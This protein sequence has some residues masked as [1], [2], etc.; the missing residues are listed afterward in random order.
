MFFALHI[1]LM[2]IATLGILAGVGAAMFFRSRK[3]WLKIHKTINSSSFVL[4]VAGIICAFIY[5]MN[6]SG[7]HLSGL[8]QWV[9]LAAVLSV[10]V[11][12]LLG[13]N[14]S[15]A[16]NKSA[17]RTAHRFGGRLGVLIFLT[18]VILGLKQIHII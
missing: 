5:T 6:S 12:L 14:Q 1:L 11:A 9:G 13:V 18:A 4:A 15:K 16:K 17:A 8:H 7:K 3:N 2:A 10:S